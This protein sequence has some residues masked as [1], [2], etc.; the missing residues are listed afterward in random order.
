MASL[1]FLLLTF[2]PLGLW[3]LWLRLSKSQNFGFDLAKRRKY[4]GWVA[5]LA[6]LAVANAFLE[7][8][9]GIF[10]GGFYA[11]RIL[12]VTATL[13]LLSIPFAIPPVHSTKHNWSL[14]LL[15]IPWLFLSIPWIG[16]LILISLIGRLEPYKKVLFE[17]A[18]HIAFTR[19]VGVMAAPT[20]E[21]RN[22]EIWGHR[23]IGTY[24]A[25]GGADST[26]IA[27]DN[28]SLWVIEYSQTLK[29]DHPHYHEM[30]NNRGQ[31]G[32]MENG[33]WKQDPKAVIWKVE[34]SIFVDLKTGQSLSRYGET[35]DPENWEL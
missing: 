27:C 30:T 26:R 9:W 16:S 13:G 23:K 17:D 28:D 1:P 32:Y 12:Y 29:P 8:Q 10:I 5:G 20:F 33:I 18:H 7:L 31:L 14:G 11:G 15:S 21:I 2:L 4:L 19:F 22:K 35:T 25:T 6:S 24:W 3:F 34:D